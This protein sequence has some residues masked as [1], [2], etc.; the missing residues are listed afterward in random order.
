MLFISIFSAALVAALLA[1][2]AL[3][4]D[5]PKGFVRLTEIDASIKQV[6]SYAGPYNFLGRAAKGYDAPVCI[7]SEKAAKAL[8]RVQEKLLGEGLSLVMFD[9][10][11]PA[12]AVADFAA[13]AKQSSGADPKWHPAVAR[14][15]LIKEGYIAFRS[16]HSRGSTVDL[17]IA[18]LEARLGEPPACGADTGTLDFGTGFDCLDPASNTDSKAVG[19]EARQNR[20]MLVEAMHAEGFRNYA[21]EWW[22]FTLAN[23]PVKKQF[24]FEVTAE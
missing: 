21:A 12:R 20:R 18:S 10:Y 15:R 24:D 13:W 8:A 9:C 4:E 6:M 5:L 3:A 23:E 2:P 22:H 7:L 17:G 14:N 1:S 11:R 19:E 16:A